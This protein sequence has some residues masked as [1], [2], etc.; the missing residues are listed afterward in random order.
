MSS[1]R[2][3]TPPLPDVDLDAV[4]R[5][6]RVVTAV[7]AA[8]LA[9]ADDVVTVLQLRVLVLAATRPGTSAT[10]VAEALGVHVSS[11]SRTIDRLVGSGLLERR[12]ASDDR[13]RLDLAPTRD[14]ERL[15]EK[16]MADRRGELQRLLSLMGEDD[17]AALARGMAALAEAAGE[18]PG[19]SP[20][21]P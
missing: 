14:G 7:I 17:R 2:R 6:S 13:R 4:L 3:G 10:D 20:L 11:A 8:S 9:R 1:T 5:G 18:P 19:P 16:V 15:L 12:E 21:I